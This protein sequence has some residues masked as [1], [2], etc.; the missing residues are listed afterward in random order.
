M[1]KV[2]D[3]VIMNDDYEV[4]EQN[5]GKEFK[6]ISDPWL[7]CGTDCVKL[8]GCAGGYAVDGLTVVR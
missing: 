5:K 8:E 7:V 6:V 2:G 3:I 1:V 4:S